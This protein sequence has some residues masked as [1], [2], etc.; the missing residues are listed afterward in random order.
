[1]EINTSF[2]EESLY[3]NR[4]NTKLDKSNKDFLNKKKEITQAI[5]L[6]NKLSSQKHSIL[7]DVLDRKLRKCE[8]KYFS[9][10]MI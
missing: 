2:D 7:N 6:F 3:L 10:K 8:R 1:M 4:W 5:E 9:E